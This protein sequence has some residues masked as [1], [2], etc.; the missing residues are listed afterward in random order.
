MTSKKEIRRSMKALRESLTEQERSA[1]ADKLGQ[2]LFQ[3]ECWKNA[4]S[5]YTYVSYN[6]EMDTYHIIRQAFLEDKR[7]FVPKVEGDDMH[8]FEIY[9]IEKDLQPGAY[10]IMEPNTLGEDISREGLMIIPGLAF[11]RKKNRLGYGGGFYDRYLKRPN[12]HCKV[13]IGFDFQIIERI[14]TDEYDI[15]VDYIVTPSHI[16]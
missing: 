8:F 14:P 10:G 9:D 3:T 11:D 4:G 12:T 16:L 7:V 6:G 13:A 1:A 5:V 2:R 15:P